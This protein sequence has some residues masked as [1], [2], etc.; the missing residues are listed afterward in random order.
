MSIRIL[1]D[2][3]AVLGTKNTTYAL[4]LKNSPAHLYWGTSVRRAEDFLAAQA[5]GEEY[6]S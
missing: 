5:I 6:A 3:V 2:S 1:N 4:T